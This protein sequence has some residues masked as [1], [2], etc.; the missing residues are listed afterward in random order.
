LFTLVISYLL[1]TSSSFAGA[2][3][4]QQQE[5]DGGFLVP[6]RQPGVLVSTLLSLR[7]FIII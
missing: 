4:S 3:A 1:E 2:L 7:R 5:L 6:A